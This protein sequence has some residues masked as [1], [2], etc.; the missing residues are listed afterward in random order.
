MRPFPACLVL[1]LFLVPGTMAVSQGKPADSGKPS[2]TASQRKDSR[3]AQPAPRPRVTTNLGAFELAPQQ[4]VRETVSVSGASRGAAG[5]S[6]PVL[7]APHLGKLYGPSPRFAWI[8]SRPARKYVFL[9][10]DESQEEIYRTEVVRAEFQ[11]PVDAPPLEPGKTYYWQIEP[12][13]LTLDTAPSPP[14]GMQVVS[15]PELQ[16]LERALSRIGPSD[17]YEA[18]LARAQLFRDHGLWYDALAAYGD[19]IERNPDRAELYQQRAE[20]YASLDTTQDLAARDTARAQEIGV[21]K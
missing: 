11:Y 2:P 16:E 20:I 13:P 19:L 21:R 12:Q 5:Q 14:A 6:A 10:M 1:L 3:A 9:L 8:F 18:G 4:N 7:L 15:G 17:S